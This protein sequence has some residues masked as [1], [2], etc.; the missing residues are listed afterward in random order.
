MRKAHFFGG[1]TT[2]IKNKYNGY[3]VSV[4]DVDGLVEAVCRYNKMSIL[5]RN[6]IQLNCIETASR[7]FSTTVIKDLATSIKAVFDVG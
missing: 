2:Y 5:E 1:L 6:R 7:Y 4:G 3:L